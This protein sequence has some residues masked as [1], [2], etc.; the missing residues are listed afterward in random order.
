MTAAFATDRVEPAF[1]RDAIG[2]RAQAAA[3][4]LADRAG[5]EP[6][7]TL[8]PAAIDAAEELDAIRDWNAQGRFPAK[9]GFT[10]AIGDVIHVRIAPG[11]ARTQSAAGGIVA[12]SERGTNVWSGSIRVEGAYRMRVHLR[13]VAVPPGTTFWVYGR[14]NDAIAFGPELIDNAGELYTPSVAGDLAYLEMELPAGSA[15]AAFDVADV[16][17]LVGSTRVEPNDAPT[18]LV[19]ATC[20]SSATLDVI[21]LYRRAVADLYYVKGGSG[22][23]CTGGLINDSDSA[24]FIPYLLTANHCFS[25]QTVATT[26]EAFWDYRT[27]SCGGLFPPMSASARSNGSTLLGTGSASDFTFV[28]LNSV[29]AGRAFLGWDARTSIITAGTTLYRVSH[30]FPD[31]FTDPAPQRFSTT[32]ISLTSLTCSARPRGPYIYSTQATGGVYGG[33]SGSPV[34]LAGG[35]VVGQLFGSCGPVDPSAG[36]DATNLTLDGAFSTT[37]PAISNYIDATP[38]ATCTPNATTACMLNNRFKV[39]VRYRGGFDNNPADSNANVKSVTGF[40]NPSFETAFFYFNSE[41]NIEMMVKI[42]DQGNTN[43]QGQPTIAVLFGSATPLRV[44]L[45]IQD[46]QKGA[47]KTYQ[48]A[49]GA[50]QGTT[51][52]TAFVK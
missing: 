11:E 12:T 24:T 48:S 39:T 50:M 32:L 28:R 33:S 31:A 10:R 36:C 47:T 27:S 34:I 22:F 6:L 40:A 14:D 4:H 29:P 52:F 13:N 41:S 43:G 15:G 45:T 37:Y 25:T 16:L 20:V 19:D 26:L 1:A 49:F 3:P 18:C 23:V 44:E 30:P 35:Y 8:A 5:I 42:L 17:E 51:D 7:A 21:D 2:L 46:M 9:N 38:S